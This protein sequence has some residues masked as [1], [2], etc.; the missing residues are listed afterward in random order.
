VS[1][2]CTVEGLGTS[3]SVDVTFLTYIYLPEEPILSLRDSMGSKT[4]L[5]VVDDTPNI[6][7]AL[8]RMLSK[9][10]DEVHVLASAAEAA[11]FLSGRPVTHVICDHCLGEGDPLGI[12]LVPVWRKE[13]PSIERAVIL[14]GLDETTLITRPGIDAIVSKL[15]GTEELVRVLKGR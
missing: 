14:T 9:H 12:E 6:G 1:E 11:A 4:I 7:R 5:M 8:S 2:G 3:L 10:F 13:H 15:T